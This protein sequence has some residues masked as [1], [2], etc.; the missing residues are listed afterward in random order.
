MAREIVV[1][2]EAVCR[3]FEQVPIDH[4]TLQFCERFD[5]QSRIIGVSR[6]KW[7]DE[8]FRNAARKDIADFVE[9]EYQ[10]EKVIER[11][12]STFCYVV[13]DVT[14][15]SK[16]GDLS[17]KLRDDP[18]SCGPSTWRSRPTCS[19]RPANTSTRKA[20][21]AATRVW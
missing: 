18:R 2:R 13:N 6:T 7:S 8:D 10:D 19:D 5:E 20:T 4:A 21:T 14:D 11:F 12:A 9:K 16:W 1:D 15:Q 3:F 17:T